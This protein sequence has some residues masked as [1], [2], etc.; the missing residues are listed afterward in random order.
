MFIFEIDTFFSVCRT[1]GGYIIFPG[2]KIDN[3][4]T[5]NGARGL[6]HRIKDRFDLTL[7]CIRCHYKNEDSPLR[8]T[9]QRYSGFFD[10]FHDF[11]GYVDF[12][13]LQDLV[14]ENYS[15]IK[16]CFPFNGFDYPPLPNNVYEYRTYKENMTN[17]VLARNQR[18]LIQSESG[19]R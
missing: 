19:G 14:E 2:K 7:E 13:L 16:F 8:D 15:S 5:I 6:N 9:L 11:Q 12:F 4:M 1:I 3:K 17:F 18:I 10:L